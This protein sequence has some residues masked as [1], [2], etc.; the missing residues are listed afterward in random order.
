MSYDIFI[1]E[2][3]SAQMSYD[4]SIEENFSA[5][6]SYDIGINGLFTLQNSKIKNTYIVSLLLLPKR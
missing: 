1:K 4:I 3:S 5:Q 2:N 6:M